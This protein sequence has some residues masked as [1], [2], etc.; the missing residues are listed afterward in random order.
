MTGRYVAAKLPSAFITGVRLTPMR[1]NAF[2]AATFARSM[3]PAE[4]SPN[5]LACPA[6]FCCNRARACVGVVPFSTAMPYRFRL[7]VLPAS[8][9]SMILPAAPT[10]ICRARARSS[11]TGSAFIA[12][13][14]LPAE[15]AM[16]VSASCTS[17]SSNPDMS[18]RLF[19]VAS[20][21][22]R[23]AAVF[24]PSAFSCADS[25]AFDASASDAARAAFVRPAASPTPI[26]APA[27]PPTLPTIA[28]AGIAPDFSLLP[29]PCAS[30]AACDVA[31]RNRFVSAVMMALSSRVSVAM[32]LALCLSVHGLDVVSQRL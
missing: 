6:N 27:T 8:T 2:S 18:E 13:S 21:F 17:S 30:R 14:A 11:V 23:V 3:P 19:T 5:A 12:A 15:R 26:A 16:P 4:V 31:W 28:S 22:A 20:I 9:F 29:K 1:S 7:V 10:S 24:C 32:L 25:L